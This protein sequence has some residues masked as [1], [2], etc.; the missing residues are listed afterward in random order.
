LKNGNW[1]IQD[2]RWEPRQEYESRTR[3]FSSEAKLDAVR[4]RAVD[5]MLKQG[6]LEPKRRKR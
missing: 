3:T 4:C 5:E 6:M 1:N 2:V